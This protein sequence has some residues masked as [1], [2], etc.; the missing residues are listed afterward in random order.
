MYGSIAAHIHDQVGGAPDGD[1]D[2]E[3]QAPRAAGRDEA[4][5]IR[6]LAAL[7]R[8]K[9]AELRDREAEARDAIDWAMA[10]KD[11]AAAAADREAAARDRERAFNDRLAAQRIREGLVHQL[12][13]AHTDQLT[14]ARTRAAGLGDID[15]EI[16]R[17]RRTS[18]LLV[19]AYVDVVGLKV[20]N[21]AHGH[22]A[23]DALLARIVCKIRS[24]LRTYDV[25]VR[26]GGDEF[27]C[28]MPGATIQD[29]HQRFG[30]IRAALAG[31]PDPSHIKC[32]FAELGRQDGTAE[33]IGRAD[34][35]LPISAPR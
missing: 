28:A 32:G 7:V 31:D 1:A 14:G 23:G 29:A 26:L 33:L 12:A 22:A 10:A 34:A 2:E 25:I 13:I 6:D 20:V 16:D 19:A 24:H 30:A 8:D 11:R 5:R 3:R 18:G 35:Q 4:A 17:A 15:R 21:D 9:S 27:L